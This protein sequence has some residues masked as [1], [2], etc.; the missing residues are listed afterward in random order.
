MPGSCDPGNL[1]HQQHDHTGPFPHQL[2]NPLLREL[3]PTHRAGGELWRPLWGTGHQPTWGTYVQST[4]L[5]HTEWTH[6]WL[7]G[8]VSPLLAHSEK[9]EAGPLCVPWPTQC[10]AD[11]VEALHPGS[12]QANPGGFSQRAW[13]TCPWYEAEDWERNWTTISHQGQKERCLL[14]TKRS[15]QPPSAKQPWG[16][17]AIWW[18]EACRFQSHAR[19]QWVPDPG[20]KRAVP[21]VPGS[22][23][24]LL[25]T[26]GTWIYLQW[27]W[28]MGQGSGSK[29]E[30]W[31]SQV[32]T[33][34][35]VPELDPMGPRGFAC[36][37]LGEVAILIHLSI[38]KKKKR[39]K[40]I[41]T[42]VGVCFRKNMKWV[43]SVDLLSLP[44]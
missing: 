11:W 7:R 6:L 25:A 44:S 27:F 42:L 16:P 43:G 12:R 2:Q 35:P 13:E 20:V 23:D 9:G 22:T 31:F 15:G 38:F 1:P 14:P 26:V 30:C 3:L 39:R 21:C 37:I 17:T 5:P 19:P 29:R 33:S 34:G 36:L 41:C 28:Q 32:L 40:K 8:G 4:C 24:F 18:E 10:G